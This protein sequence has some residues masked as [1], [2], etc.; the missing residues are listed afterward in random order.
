MATKD[1]F[2]IIYWFISL[3]ILAYTVYWIYQSP[4]KAVKIGRDLDVEQNKYKAKSDL[5]LMLF[6]L[7][8]NP[9]S[10]DYVNGL[11]KIDIVFQDEEKVLGA[12]GKLFDS[13][14]RKDQV[15]AVSEW[16]RLR[17]D[18]LSTMAESL[19]YKSIKQTV[20]QQH[21]S[22]QAHANWQL[23]NQSFHEVQ[24]AY[25]QSGA[26]MHNLVIASYQSQQ[27]P[28]EESGTQ[29]FVEQQ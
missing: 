5:F 7:R 1:Y 12:W 28:N 2:E 22:P 20:I 10:Y 11:N 4:I 17:T 19:G 27:P 29:P 18:L 13:L 6:S 14:N 25:Y 24:R 15:D 21:Y 26:L 16:D 23:D 3:V 8:G 9:M